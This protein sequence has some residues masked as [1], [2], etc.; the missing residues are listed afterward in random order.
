MCHSWVARRLLFSEKLLCC[1][2]KA[3]P[4]S[5]QPTLRSSRDAT[6]MNCSQPAEQEKDDRFRF[7]VTEDTYHCC[8]LLFMFLWQHLSLLPHE[9]S[10][11]V[12]NL[13][14]DRMSNVQLLSSS[15]FISFRSDLRHS[16]PFDH[17]ARAVTS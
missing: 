11:Q 13:Y 10:Q 2:I 9:K 12:T 6:E 8:S 17:Q 5:K 15:V 4:C 14:Y 7:Q 3:L 1:Y 16:L